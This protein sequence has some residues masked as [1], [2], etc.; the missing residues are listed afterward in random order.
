MILTFAILIDNIFG[1]KNI[2]HPVIF[3]G[4]LINLYKKIFFTDINS[5]LRGLVVCFLTLTTTG[6]FVFLILY[7][8]HFNVIIQIFLIYSA[9]AWRDLKDETEKIFSCLINND[10]KNARKF[11][12]YVVGRDTENLN[13][14][15]I[16]RATIETISENSIDGIISV[17]FYAGIGYYFGKNLGMCLSVWIFKAA[18]TLDSMIGYESLGKFGTASARLD[19]ILNFIPA[20]I[21]SL[22]IIFAGFLLTGKNLKHSL[23]IFLTDRKKHKSPNSAH[24]E[25]AFAGILNIKLGGNSFYNGVLKIRPLINSEAPEP[26]IYDI[27]RAW[28]LLDISCSLFAV[29]IILILWKI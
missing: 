20:R 1:D 24:G 10:I 27:V 2:Y 23:K 29:L 8:F 6:L 22:I 14:N 26:K 12:S 15:E 17:I 9:L 11:L 3:I 28:K 25:S 5:F 21:G 4:K 13:E 16:I 18:S 7:I 19:D